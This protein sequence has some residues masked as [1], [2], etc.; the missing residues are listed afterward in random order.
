M[1]DGNER[2]ARCRAQ[3]APPKPGAKRKRKRKTTS[4]PRRKKKAASQPA[5]GAAAPPAEAPTADIESPV[6][7]QVE[8]AVVESS[9]SM[10]EQSVDLLDAIT[11]LEAELQATLEAKGSLQDKLS[12]ANQEA[13]QLRWRNTELQAKLNEA[14][15]GLAQMSTLQQELEFSEQQRAEASQRAAALEQQLQ[16]ASEAVETGQAEL[17]SLKTRCDEVED[18]RHAV[19]AEVLELRDVS[20]RLDALQEEHAAARKELEQAR[21]AREEV[22]AELEQLTA[23]NEAQEAQLAQ[24]QQLVATLRKTIKQLT[25]RV[26]L[27]E[28]ERKRQGCGQEAA[29][30]AEARAGRHSGGERVAAGGAGA[31]PSSLRANSLRPRSGPVTCRHGPAPGGAE[32]T[33][34]VLRSV[35]SRVK[36][37]GPRMARLRGCGL[38]WAAR[39]PHPRVGRAPGPAVGV[40]T[41]SV[42]SR[43]GTFQPDNSDADLRK[44]ALVA[45]PRTLRPWCALPLRQSQ[46]ALGGTIY[47]E[48][49]SQDVVARGAMGALAAG[50]KARGGKSGPGF[51]VAQGR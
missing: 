32:G 41:R 9:P 13:G 10:R 11:A 45:L 50:P 6:Q 4:E 17:T 33:G 8:A 42:G 22:D 29:G 31:G 23:A 36:G 34:L 38:Q 25:E 24:Q 14:E 27:S 43:S 16:Q 21:V 18:A 49:R 3:A 20:L 5:A 7:Q 12:E 1:D 40:P 26:E 46:R 28:G 39:G 44:Q 47:F 19:T 37:S 30:R 35:S 2:T 15:D 48:G 51:R